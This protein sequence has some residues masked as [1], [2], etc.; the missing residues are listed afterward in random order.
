M[1]T[2][3]PTPPAAPLK[4]RERRRTNRLRPRK[5]L[6]LRTSAK[7]ALQVLDISAS[8][9]L[10]EHATPFMPGSVCELELR[11]STTA[12]RLLVQVVRC[13]VTK[14]SRAHRPGILYRTA[15]QF[16]DAPSPTLFALLKELAQG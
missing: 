7:V 4:P 8:G 14:D 16:M 2:I 10:V 13:V 1:E 3:A 12:I 15:F 9:L 6:N 11:I 5:P